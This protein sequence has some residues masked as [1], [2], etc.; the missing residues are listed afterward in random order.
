MGEPPFFLDP[1][2]G[3]VDLLQPVPFFGQGHFTG[4]KPSHFDRDGIAA[5]IQGLDAHMG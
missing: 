4:S 2:N 5:L 3:V 1:L